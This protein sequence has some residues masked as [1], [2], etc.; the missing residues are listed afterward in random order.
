MS[1]RRAMGKSD[2]S[3]S[4]E[5]QV[6][7]S[8]LQ[9]RFGII[10]LAVIATS[11]IA[12]VPPRTESGNKSYTI[13]LSNNFV[14]NDWRQQ[15]LRSAEIAAKKRPLAG[16]INLKIENVE[17]TAEAQIN[18]LNNIIR[19]RP[20]AI[21][22]DAASATALNPT[23]EKAC[24]AGILV[25]TFDQITTTDCAYGIDTDWTRAGAVEV[26]WIARKLSGK[27]K[28]LVDRGLAG[29]P[30]SD[31]LLNGY[32]NAIREYPSIQ[33]VGYFNGDYSLG[34]EQAG[35]ANL[36]AA[37]PEVDAMLVQGYGAGAIRALLD[38][39][40]K[41][42]PVTGSSFNLSTVTC[43]QTPGAACMLTS[44]PAYLSAEALKLAVSI[45]DGKIPPQKHIFVGSPFL[46]TDP[47][48]SK[49]FPDAVI[50]KIAIGKNA[51]PD[52]APGLCLPFSPGWVEIKPQE[53]G[54]S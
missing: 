40:R 9:A 22:I 14:G 15:M 5:N 48:P 25:V 17:T 21:L 1:K 30:V 10:A 39:G 4:A 34:A 32:V 41:V 37:H 44:N 29:A 11:L 13:Y 49:V 46:T 23:I 45:L 18:S 42:V 52:L 33:I 26:E 6:R 8:R 31:R 43:A 27:G 16:R 47:A 36:L 12:C 35:V 2:S 53:L 24:K 19:T 38:A 54:G 50:E 7:G 20:D 28:I 51:F 3:A